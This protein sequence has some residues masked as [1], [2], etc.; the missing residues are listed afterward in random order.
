LLLQAPLG[1]LQSVFFLSRHCKAVQTAAAIRFPEKRK[2]GAL[3][4]MRLE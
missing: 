3:R 4:A 2:N 1:A